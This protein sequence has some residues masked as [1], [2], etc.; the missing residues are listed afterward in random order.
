M[1]KLLESAN[2]AKWIPPMSSYLLALTDTTLSL[3]LIP[4]LFSVSFTSLGGGL[5]YSPLCTSPFAS[6]YIFILVAEM[7]GSIVTQTWLMHLTIQETLLFSKL[8]IRM[9]LS[10]F[11]LI[12]SP[13]IA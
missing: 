3:S 4:M 10:P 6:I 12:R 1:P 7:D 13:A 2:F 8:F 9:L 5:Q 11:Y